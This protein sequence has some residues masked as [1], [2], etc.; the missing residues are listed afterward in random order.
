MIV[1]P[2]PAVPERVTQLDNLFGKRAI[3]RILTVFRNAIDPQHRECFVRIEERNDGNVGMATT[4]IELN[5][6]G[7]RFI[8]TLEIV[9]DR[10]SGRT[11]SAKRGSCS[12]SA[13]ICGS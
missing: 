7:P 9:G 8:A 11:L 5:E 2:A 10:S 6:C 13:G 3:L 1:D 12:S 4:C